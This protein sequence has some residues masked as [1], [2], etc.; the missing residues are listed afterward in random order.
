MEAPAA[1][2]P[3]LNADGKAMTSQEVYRMMGMLRE[4]N[5]WLREQ[6][7]RNSEMMDV[8]EKLILANPSDATKTAYLEMQQINNRSKCVAQ[9]TGISCDEMHGS[10][11]ALLV[12]LSNANFMIED[13]NTKC[14]RIHDKI[15]TADWTVSIVRAG[16][17]VRTE[18][19]DERRAILTELLSAIKFPV[20]IF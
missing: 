11:L 14:V 7:R 3:I 12:R 2:T 13:G 4:R 6:Q 10:H 9:V 16:T 17:K 5:E 20:K 15:T 8:M 19:S 1:A 18:M